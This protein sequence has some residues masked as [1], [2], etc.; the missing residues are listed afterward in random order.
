MVSETGSSVE[1]LS[2]EERTTEK[3]STA[4]RIK[5][6]KSLIFSFLSEW[7]TAKAVLMSDNPPVQNP[8]RPMQ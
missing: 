7:D 8:Y 3:T 2:A 4:K 6:K 5:Q 1:T